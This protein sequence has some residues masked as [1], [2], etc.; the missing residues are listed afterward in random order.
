VSFETA[1]Y[2]WQQG[3]RR[4]AAAPPQQA[5]TLERVVDALASELRRR[6]GGRFTSQELVDLYEAGTG[7]CQQ[8]AMTVAPQDPWA[9]DAAVVADAAFARYLR[10]AADFAGGRREVGEVA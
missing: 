4:I 8:T 10:Q 9:W 5:R 2:Q 7:W 6:L 1:L 3:E